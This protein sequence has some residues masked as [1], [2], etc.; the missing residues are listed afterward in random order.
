M[1]KAGGNKMAKAFAVAAALCAFLFIQGLDGFAQQSTNPAAIVAPP[2]KIGAGDLLEVNMFENPDLSGRFRVDEHGDIVIPLVGNLHVEGLT[3]EQAAALIER[4]F[5]E[6][7]I[8]QPAESHA[9]VF[10]AEYANQGITVNG[11]VKST[12]I[13]PALGVRKLNDV[14]SAAGGVTPLA[15]SRVVITHRTD[16]GSPVTVDYNPEA[17]PPV[18]PDVQVFPGDTVMV[19]RAGLVYVLGNVNRAGAYVLDGRRDLTLEELMAL[20][21]GGG[22]AAAMKRVQLVRSLQDGRKEAI[23]VPVNLIYKGQAPDVSLK[24]G[25]IVYVPTSNARYAA[26]QALTAAVSIGT[27]IAVYRT[28]TNQ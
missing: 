18:I 25:D 3:A 15:S 19:P 2:L 1:A 14:I 9:T 7:Q 8:L 4:R 6:A 27:S 26:E 24:D 20:A 22:H 28:A 5:V 16:P 17:L 12:G 21:G 10:I 13:Y 11:Q 23:T